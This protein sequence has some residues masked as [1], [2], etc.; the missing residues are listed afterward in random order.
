MA[1]HVFNTMSGKKELLQPIHPPVVR[2]Y[3]CG[4]TVY[5]PMHIGHARTYCFWD[6]LRRFL[7]YRGMT[8]MS[9][10]NYTDIDD[11]I[12]DRSD[13][14]K[15]PC[16]IAEEVIAGFRRDCRSLMIKDYAAYTRATDFISGQ[17]EMIRQLI[18]AGHAYVTEGEVLYDVSSFTRYGQLSGRKLEEQLA[19]ASGRIG[20]DLERKRHPAD[21]TLWKPSAPGDPSWLTGETEWPSGRPGWHIE[22]SVMSSATLGSTFDLHGGAIDNLF[23]HHENELAQ[24]QPLCGAE[25]W[26]RYWMH[27]A[28]LDLAGEKM[29]K[30]LGNVITVPAL[31]ERFQPETIRWFFATSHYRSKVGFGD[32]MVS[33][34]GEG[35]ERILRLIR[36]LGSRL[37]GVADE[38]LQIPVAGE[39]ASLRPQEAA[40]PRRRHRYTYGRFGEITG[41]MIG[42]FTTAM[43]DDLSCPRAVAALFDY[44]NE[45][46]AAGIETSA[47]DVDTPSLLA[48]YQALLRH[49]Y[50]LGVELPDWRLYP[51]LAAESFPVSG[52]ETSSEPYRAFID[53][54]LSIRKQARE[55]RDYARADLIRDLL[56][57]AGLQVE[58]TPE[59]PRWQLSGSHS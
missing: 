2:I 52:D 55:D 38:A 43:D 27:P 13:Q 29:S 57:E 30:S 9:V 6:V 40:A 25:Q 23:P 49:L 10:I 12:L 54:L 35:L 32:E 41:R 58:D 14:R 26:V 39:Y 33:A 15:G 1:L 5:S 8:V 45:L 28:H 53:R 18:A 21:F 3:T 50:V 42:R 36:G 7:E 48:V 4:L 47:P 20:E 17:I 22:C 46:Y 31:L 34:A 11:R 19:G 56:A 44:V 37:A 59:G 51:E 24:S 16:D